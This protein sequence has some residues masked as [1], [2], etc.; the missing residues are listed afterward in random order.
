MSEISGS[1]FQELG[2]ETV[3][4]AIAEAEGTTIEAAR[5]KL[6]A[7]KQLHLNKLKEAK[8]EEG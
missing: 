7:A 4:K 6:Q 8:G 3:A 2:E 5:T 1:Q